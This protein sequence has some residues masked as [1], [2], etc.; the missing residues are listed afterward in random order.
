MPQFSGSSLRI[1]IAAA[2]LNQETCA[3]EAFK[4][5][6]F[7]FSLIYLSLIYFYIVR[8]KTLEKMATQS[9]SATCFT[10]LVQE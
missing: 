7:Y 9:R 8:K 5:S 4:N 3:L 2:K 1:L 10:F 6:F